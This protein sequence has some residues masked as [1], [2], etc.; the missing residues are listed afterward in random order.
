MF[1]RFL[2]GLVFGA[3]FSLAFVAIIAAVFWYTA[4]RQFSFSTGTSA[5]PIHSPEITTL[6]SLPPLQETRGFLGSTGIY[7]GNFSGRNQLLAAG[8]GEI[9]G[10]AHANGEPVAGLRL[11]L[12]LN[13][14]AMSQWAVT[15]QQGFYR[16]SVPYGSYSL[17][18]FELDGQSAN[19][20]LPNKIHRP[21]NY[22]Y[23]S[24]ETIEVSSDNTGTGIAFHFVDPVI[25]KPGKKHYAPD[26]AITLMWQA[27]P[28]AAEYELRLYQK[29]DRDSWQRSLVL[30]WHDR[31][32]VFEPQINLAES[33]ITLEPGKYYSYEIYARDQEHRLIT[34]TEEK[35]RGYDFA[36]GLP[37]GE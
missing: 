5:Y 36:I 26:E 6:D 12:A 8:P 30:E 10:Q 7:S 18:G 37:L 29:E 1:K 3:G 17:T 2:E 13:N 11:R 23:F 4:N 14:S 15:D 35:H 16:I 20:V 21:Q 31:I 25:K 24:D 22:P 32:T 34:A 9:V 33:G 19:Q 28:G 27:Y